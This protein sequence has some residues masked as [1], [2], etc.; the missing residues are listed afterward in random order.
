MSK[1][2]TLMIVSAMAMMMMV[3]GLPQALAQDWCYWGCNPAYWSAPAAQEPDTECGWV[4][5]WV[6]DDWRGH[7]EQ[8]W[9][10]WQD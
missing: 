1:I 6:S 10:C 4:W 7:W 2:R 8:V 3:V 9:A 5:V